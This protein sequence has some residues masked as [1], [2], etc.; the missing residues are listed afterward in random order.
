M[1]G[2]YKF[3]TARIGRVPLDRVV[4]VD[5]LDTWSYANSMTFDHYIAEPSSV[6]G[7]VA[8]RNQYGLAWLEVSKVWNLNAGTHVANVRLRNLVGPSVGHAEDLIFDV[9]DATTLSTL[10]SVTIPAASQQAGVW[11]QSPD[12]V[13]TLP[14]AQ[15]VRF[16]IR[17]YA[18][19]GAN[20][21]QFDSFTLRSS[22]PSFSAY[23]AGCHGLTLTQPVGGQ[24]GSALTL[25]IGNGGNALLGIFAFGSPVSPVPLDFLGATGCLLHVTPDALLSGVFA[26]GACSTSVALPNQPSLFGITL[27]VQGA[28]FDPSVPGSLKT[29]NAGQS[30]LGL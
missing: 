26:G 9:L 16:V 28:A 30:Y 17:N 23:G 25:A 7:R 8:Q 20:G 2:N 15:A 3:D 24:L 19:W 1:K 14:T 12:L 29:A 22:S 5:S 13:V 11:V 6:Y 18:M 27:N 21:Y 10:A 4:Q